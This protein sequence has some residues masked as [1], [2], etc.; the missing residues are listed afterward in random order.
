MILFFIGLFL[1]FFGCLA[2]LVFCYGIV[3]IIFLRWGADIVEM[4]GR[5]ITTLEDSVKKSDIIYPD[6]SE[7]I[8]KSDVSLDNILE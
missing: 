7:D 5:E 8:I 6:L 3:K 2:M 1:G 4:T